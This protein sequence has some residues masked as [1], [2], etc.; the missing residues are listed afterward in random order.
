M[1]ILETNSKLSKET[2]PRREMRSNT[3]VYK[4]EIRCTN[5]LFCFV[6]ECVQ[7]YEL[8]VLGTDC[9]RRCSHCAVRFDNLLSF[10]I[11]QSIRENNINDWRTCKSPQT[12]ENVTSY[13]HYIFVYFRFQNQGKLPA[14]FACQPPLTTPPS[15]PPP[16]SHLKHCSK[17]P[18]YL[19]RVIRN[20]GNNANPRYW[21]YFK[22]YCKTLLY[23]Y[24]R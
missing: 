20:H 12:F 19:I 18:Q 9:L 23:F 21:L 4:D 16:W 11:S 10:N 1:S 2:T 24:H 5:Q 15:S 14:L 6:W 7:K 17:V 8:T 3:A 22:E 13:G